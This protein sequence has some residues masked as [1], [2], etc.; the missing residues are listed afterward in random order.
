ML[1]RL[2]LLSAGVAYTHENAEV[3]GTSKIETKISSR[4]QK[5]GNDLG[6]STD[7]A[8]ARD[9]SQLDEAPNAAAKSGSRTSAFGAVVDDPEDE[10]L[11]GLDADDGL[12]KVRYKYRPPEEVRKRQFCIMAKMFG[13]EGLEGVTE[14]ALV[15]EGWTQEERRNC[16]E[17]FYRRRRKRVAEL[18]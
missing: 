16:L 7:Y 13:Y 1:C 6:M 12:G 14:F 11:D 3:I 18:R 17:N 9:Q 5:A 8:F 2:S 15:V 4:A 10:D